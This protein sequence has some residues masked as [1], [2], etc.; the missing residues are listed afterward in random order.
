MQNSLANSLL[1]LIICRE[2]LH[3]LT[4]RHQAM[5]END[6]GINASTSSPSVRN[7]IYGRNEEME[8]RIHDV[9][10]LAESVD[11]VAAAVSQSQP[12]QPTVGHGVSELVETRDALFETKQALKS[13]LSSQKTG[14]NGLCFPFNI[15]PKQGTSGGTAAKVQVDTGCE[16]NWIRADILERAGLLEDVSSASIDMSNAYAGFGGNSLTPTGRVLVVWFSENQR[17]TRQT[18]FLVHTDVPFDAV[19]GRQSILEDGG[20]AFA[21][22]LLALRHLD[23]N[24]GEFQ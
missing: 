12:Q 18:W 11:R 3:D 24:K 7:H 5:I 2:R 9:L 17:L 13:I 20:I 14:S 16:Y 1:I 15:L 21:S 8:H 23:L 10:R 22:P 6:D 4:I 19:L